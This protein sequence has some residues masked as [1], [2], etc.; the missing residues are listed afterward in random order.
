MNQKGIE[1]FYGRIS[2]GDFRFND[3]KMNKIEA[4]NK[5][6]LYHSDHFQ[7][8]ENKKV[9]NFLSDLRKA[10][11]SEGHLTK[12]KR[13]KFL[14]QFKNNPGLKAKYGFKKEQLNEM[15]NLLTETGKKVVVSENDTENN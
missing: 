4:I 3:T 15:E 7:Q 5:D 11:G 8:A 13:D 9:M 10:C 6:M 14:R 12:E 2:K 1:D